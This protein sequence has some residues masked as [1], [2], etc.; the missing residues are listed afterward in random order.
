MNPF[1]SANILSSLG[2][3]AVFGVALI[4]YLETATIFGSFLPGDSLLFLLG[5]ALA[6][7]LVQFPVWLA[8]PIVFG[9][10]VSGAQTGFYLGRKLGPRL[11]KQ[12]ETF[13]F[14]HKT[15]ERTKYFFE[16]YGARSI[17][18]AR[19]I[20]I[21]RAL[22]PM[23]AA[24]AHFD[25]R[26]FLKLNIIGGLL[27]TAGL[28]GAGYSLGHIPFVEKNIEAFV[29]GFLII[30]SLP[31]PIELILERVKRRKRAKAS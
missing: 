7:W 19:F 18:M 1:D 2:Q 14:N 31:L 20:P 3:L 8:I 30:S 11:F 13:L 5:I 12:R 27:W 22:I 25:S 21:L 26:R 15:L 10:A 29:I 9:A 23:F 4:I 24:I 6:T 17:V 28:I 16:H